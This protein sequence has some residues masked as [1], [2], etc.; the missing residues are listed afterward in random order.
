MHAKYFLTFF[1]LLLLSTSCKKP[2][3]TASPKAASSSSNVSNLPPPPAP[4]IESESTDLNGVPLQSI[5]I[6][7]TDPNNLIQ[8]KFISGSCKTEGPEKI[9]STYSDN[10]TLPVG[11]G[12]CQIAF[13][14]CTSPTTCSVLTTTNFT[15][16]EAP[17]ESKEL[18]SLLKQQFDYEQE[19]QDLGQTVSQ[20]IQKAAPSFDTCL[21]DYKKEGKENELQALKDFAK[22]T[23]QELTSLFKFDFSDQINA[24]LDELNG[25]NETATETVVHETT[26][27]ITD[28]EQTQKT[29]SDLQQFIA[30]AAIPIY[31]FVALE[32][33]FEIFEIYKWRQFVKKRK[34]LHDRRKKSRTGTP[35]FWFSRAS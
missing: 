11:S 5:Q 27:T 31:L 3:T 32:T 18:Q 20:N 2:T 30:L 35:L 15:Q 17:E 28:T 14:E 19:L 1:A 8:Y 10:V 4:K 16:T 23:P 24:I 34:N 33:A 7:K 6:T 12:A 22:I 21:A 26:K 9:Y 13:Q 29:I 25:D